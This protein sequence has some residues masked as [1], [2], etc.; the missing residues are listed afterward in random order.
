MNRL[1]ILFMV[2][3]LGL[4]L[5]AAGAGAVSVLDLN[6]GVRAIGMGGAGLARV[7]GAETLYN[8]PAGL[9]E[10]SGI[11]LGSFYSTQVGL[12]SYGAVDLTF[13]NWGLA[14]LSL[15]A[16]DIQGYDSS[17][18]QTSVLS[19]QNTAL[20]F[21]F[22]LSP[23]NIPFL[24]SLPLDFSVGGRL[25]Y[26]SV[27]NG[28]AKGSGFSVDL[29]YLMTFP[30]RRLGPISISDTAVGA[31]MTNLFGSLNYENHSD[32]FRM[33]IRVGAA[34]KIAE[35]ATVA[36]D[37]DLGGS[38]HLGMEYRPINTFALRAGFFN[39]PGGMAFTLGLGVDV[40]GFILD[41]AYV[42]GGGLTG[43]HLV[44]LSIDF[45]GIDISAFSRIFRRLLP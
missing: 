45:S 40:Q 10:L 3:L 25:K 37:I 8:N 19:Y 21:G 31:S 13:P 12:L 30:D 32:P 15:N 28:D 1:Y 43:S 22:G 17:G 24:P 36:L 23:K 18:D 5:E 4:G 34:T 33:S 11:G 38:I 44:S 26:L 42:T 9:T 35:V 27:T 7:D 16:G 41:Y 6:P 20:V 39:R 29:G 2:I 14:V